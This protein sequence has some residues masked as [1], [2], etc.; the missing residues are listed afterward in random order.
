[1]PR[2]NRKHMD[3]GDRIRIQR[4][5]EKKRSLSSIAREIGVSASTVSREVQ[6]NRTKGFRGKSRRSL[7]AK[8]HGCPGVLIAMFP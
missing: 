3:I 6:A 2:E 1:M 7:C 8:K 5:L 4:G